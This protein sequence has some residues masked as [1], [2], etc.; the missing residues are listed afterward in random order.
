MEY[1]R[2]G[3]RAVRFPRVVSVRMTDVEWLDLQSRAQL[4]GFSMS[5]WLRQTCV[6][7]SASR[8]VRAKP[9]LHPDVKRLIWEVSRIGAN[10]NQIARALNIAAKHGN[11][12]LLVETIVT[13]RA[14]ELALQGVLHAR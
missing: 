4:A 9:Q 5:E 8:P 14:I 6:T 7:Q 3:K 13:L 2:F 10:L 1:R 11:P 12:V